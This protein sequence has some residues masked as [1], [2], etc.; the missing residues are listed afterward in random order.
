MGLDLTDLRE[1]DRTLLDYLREGR[2]TPA[3]ARKRLLDETER[4]SITGAYI[5]QRL[6]RFEEH[7]HVE[8]LYDTGLYALV[9]DIEEND[10]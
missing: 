10:Q 8:N 7:G 1:I 3:Y 6:Q 4:E 9:E 2:I 5:G